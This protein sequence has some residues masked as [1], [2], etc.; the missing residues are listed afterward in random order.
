MLNITRKSI[1]TKQFAR[2]LASVPKYK[3]LPNVYNKKSSSYKPKF[4]Q[5]KGL[6][7]HPPPSA[8]SSTS[9]TPNL[10]L[11]NEDPRKGLNLGGE[12]IDI[13]NAPSLSSPSPKK[14]HL[15]PEDVA[16]IQRLRS[17][18]PYTNTRN[19][20]AEKF[21][22]SPFTISLVSNQSEQRKQDMEG[23]LTYIKD[24]WS[25]NRKEARDDRKKRSVYWYRDQ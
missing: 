2:S 14:Y 4:K 9:E 13:Q 24:H 16:E 21:N 25:K 10:F 15:T 23:R 7:Y 8:P 11:P 5:P 6:I 22:V 12:S 3:Q 1:P 20:L 17:T 18:D 19:F